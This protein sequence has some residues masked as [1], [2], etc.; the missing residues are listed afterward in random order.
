M[1]LDLERG[2]K[3]R[4]MLISELEA[5]LKSIREERGDVPVYLEYDGCINELE[6]V[7]YKTKTA[8]RNN[9]KPEFTPRCHPDYTGVH[10]D[11]YF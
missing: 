7:V 9:W 11:A 6:E 1:R 3:R 10:L 2:L 5:K 8:D 4:E